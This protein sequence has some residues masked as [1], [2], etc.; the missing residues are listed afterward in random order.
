MNV[1]CC[2]WWFPGDLNDW[3]KAA[4]YSKN[5]VFCGSDRLNPR[6]TRIATN[7]NALISKWIGNSSVANEDNYYARSQ[8]LRKRDF[9]TKS[10]DFYPLYSYAR[11][12]LFFFPFFF[13]NWIDARSLFPF[14][15]LIFSILFSLALTLQ[16]NVL[17]LISILPSGIGLL[18]PL[19]P[20]Y[21]TDAG[22]LQ[23]KFIFEMTTIEW[24]V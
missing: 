23:P 15:R 2:R 18:C 24:L 1:G 7:C 12:S 16:R 17:F 13:P 22:E 19:P 5:R 8:N 21:W 4:C 14:F 6:P 20:P 9:T 3:R 11:T 10:Q